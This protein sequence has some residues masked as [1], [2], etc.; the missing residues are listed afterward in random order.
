MIEQRTYACT[1]YT[2]IYQSP[3]TTDPGAIAGGGQAALSVGQ[4]FTGQPAGSAS[5]WINTGIGFVPDTTVLPCF[6]FRATAA[7]PIY[8]SPAADAP[9]ALDGSAA[10]APG[11]M[12]LACE[13]AP[14]WLWLT[15]GVGFV[16]MSVCAPTDAQLYTVQPNDNLSTISQQFYGNQAE[17]RQIYEANQ[18][19]IGAD[20]NLIQPGQVLIIP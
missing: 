11:D 1:Q 15:S 4:T 2:P 18:A 5:I 13:T 7:S 12:L 19:L 14:G 8:Q 9:V 6:G 10:V 3:D 16:P 17:A 20:P